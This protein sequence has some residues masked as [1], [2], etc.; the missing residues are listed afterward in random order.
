MN[1]DLGRLSCVASVFGRRVLRIE[2]SKAS[3]ILRIVVAFAFF[4]VYST[5]QPSTQP[6]YRCHSDA[7]HSHFA[8]NDEN[9]NNMGKREALLGYILKDNIHRAHHLFG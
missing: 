4:F 8:S 2:R 3:S 5:A 1:S 7:E 9:C 6:L